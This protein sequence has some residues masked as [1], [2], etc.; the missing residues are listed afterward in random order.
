M[1][2]SNLS[3]AEIKTLVRRMFKELSKDL[4]S[5]KKVQSE[6]KDTLLEIKNNLQGINSRM[7]EA[8]NQISNLGYK[9]AKTTNQNKKKKKRIQ[10]N[11]DSVR[12][13][14]DNFKRFNTHLTGMPKGEEKE[15][16]FG[17]LFEKTVKENFPNL[18]KEIVIQGCTENPKQDGCKEAQS[19]T[20]HN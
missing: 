5:I 15:Q 8:K 2:I 12:I 20:H 6:M 3:D 9:K 16:E 7:A 1:K 13:L 18:L 14:W 4:N 11:E 10:N 17:N 19:K